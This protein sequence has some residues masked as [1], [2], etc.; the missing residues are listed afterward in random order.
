MTNTN[1]NQDLDQRI[2]RLVQEHIAASRT[3]A[4][5]AAERAFALGV[6]APA[7]AARPVKA[8]QGEKRPSTDIAALGE[9]FYKA[10]STKP[11]ETMTVLAADVG[12]SAR[13]FHPVT[14]RNPC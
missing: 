5:E 11:G 9:H 7:R 4:Q 2:E 3:A 14:T 1:R 6:S 8:S 12:M 13:E 10:V